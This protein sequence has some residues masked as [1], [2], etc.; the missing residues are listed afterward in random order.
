MFPGQRTQ[1]R[2]QA[3][4]AFSISCGGGGG[5]SVNVCIPSFQLDPEIPAKGDRGQSS[6]SS[7]GSSMEVQTMV[8]NIIGPSDRSAMSTAS[9]PS[10]SSSSSGESTAS[11]SQSPQLQV[12]HVASIRLSLLLQNI[13]ERVSKILLASWKERTEKRYESAWKQFCRWCY[14]KSVNPF[15]YHLDGILLYLSDLYEIG[16]QYRTINSHRSVISMTHLPIDNVCAGAH[17]LIS[18]LMKGIFKIHPAVKRYL[19]TWDV[20]VVLKY[21]ISLSPAPFYHLK[22]WL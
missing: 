10:L 19:K 9:G 6:G 12:S 1:L 17:P 22:N 20:S 5:G 13:P 11:S 21:L 18:R 16:L 15:S 4:D 8:S 7:Y 14:K 2:A 3:I